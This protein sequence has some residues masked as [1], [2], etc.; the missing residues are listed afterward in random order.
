MTNPKEIRI[1]AIQVRQGT[2]RLIYSFAVD[3]KLVPSFA[4]VSRIRRSG[5]HQLDG[6]QRPEVLSHIAEIRNYIETEAPMVPNAIVIAF[7]DRVRFELS[8]GAPN[9][10]DYA[11]VG[12]LIIPVDDTIDE[13]EKPGFIVDGQQRLAAIREANVESFPVCVSAFITSDMKEQTEQF[14]LVNS[15]KPL[16][17]GLIYELLPHTQATLPVLLQRRRFPAY[18]LNLLNHEEDSPL[19]GRIQTP[20]T[21]NG[22]IKDNSILKMLENSL[23]DGVLYRFRYTADGAGDVDKITAVLQNFWGAVREVFSEAWNLPPRRS[24]LVHGAGIIA[25]G[26][27]MDAIAERHRKVAI[28]TQVIFAEDLLPLKEVCRWTDGYWD[29]GP[30]R[31]RKW[32]EIQ[33]TTK[34]I[35]VLANY[36]LIQ[37][38]SLVWNQESKAIKERA[39]EQSFLF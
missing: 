37:Y 3:G 11:K 14:I 4:T 35:Q 6:Y 27:L 30:G 36:L 22:D 9:G 13:T 23:S 10:I 32:N 31:Q 15:T 34:D 7:D 25:L 1:P 24:R 19:K 8:T 5:A 18:L 17:K 39:N 20:T 38:K 26:F 2:K 16:P 33:N 21:P 12:T 28:P 29:F